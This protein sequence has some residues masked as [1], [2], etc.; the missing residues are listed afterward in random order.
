MI[1][2]SNA[3]SGVPASLAEGS[4]SDGAS[5]KTRP[6]A[7]SRRLRINPAASRSSA[8]GQAAP[9]RPRASS[10]RRA[11]AIPKHSFPSC[12]RMRAAVRRVNG[13]AALFLLHLP[14]IPAS[15]RGSSPYAALQSAY[16][17]HKRAN[18]P[19]SQDPPREVELTGRRGR[20][21][22]ERVTSA[23]GAGR[24]PNPALSPP[25][26]ASRGLPASSCP[27]Y[28]LARVKPMRRKLSRRT[29]FCRLGLRPPQG[30]C[31]QI[32]PGR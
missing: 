10:P 28:P 5:P 2:R 1:A 22:P 29:G 19:G 11:R 8:L 16:G 9:P 27:P 14:P 4:R 32:P 20:L 7:I 17:G 6:E 30:R 12:S 13:G 26:A 15:R 25:R 24:A 23:G 18:R 21:G 3:S 31:P